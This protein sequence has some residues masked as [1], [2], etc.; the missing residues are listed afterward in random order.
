MQTY[1]LSSC[2]GTP[3][4]AE[5]ANAR[6]TQELYLAQTLYSS[7]APLQREGTTL[8]ATS[9][10]SSESLMDQR[11]RA[12]GLRPRSTHIFATSRKLEA[13]ASYYMLEI[14]MLRNK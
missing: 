4:A 5:Q 6:L 1:F 12:V 7:S 9:L 13:S 11:I 14:D 10:E 3:R 2:C 8:M